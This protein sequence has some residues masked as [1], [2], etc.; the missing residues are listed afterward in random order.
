MQ[1]N[2]QTYSGK[3]REDREREGGVHVGHMKW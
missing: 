3:M 2:G 1:I